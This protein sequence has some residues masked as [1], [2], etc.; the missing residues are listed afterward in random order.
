MNNKSEGR[1]KATLCSKGSKLISYR[2]PKLAFMMPADI[3]KQ[4]EA[5]LSRSWSEMSTLFSQRNSF[6][7]NDRRG[8]M[9]NL[10]IFSR[11]AKAQ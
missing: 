6:A 5:S 1:T 10:F 4:K 2:A 11:C 7:A 3:T 8:K 9:Q